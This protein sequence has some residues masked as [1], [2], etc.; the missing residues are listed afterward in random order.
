[1]ENIGLTIPHKYYGALERLRDCADNKR[2]PKGQPITNTWVY[3]NFRTIMERLTDWLLDEVVKMGYGTE[4][5]SCAFKVIGH[6]AP[7]QVV[8]QKS[9]NPFDAYWTIT[10]IDKLADQYRFGGLLEVWQ[11]DP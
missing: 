10:V 2:G 9:D 3:H 1:M 7:G 4:F 8:L 6:G 5:R 11:N